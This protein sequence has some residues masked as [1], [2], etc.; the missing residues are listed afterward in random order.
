M[1]SHKLNLRLAEEE[2]KEYTA[3]AIVHNAEDMLD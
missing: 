2:G 3:H 1:M